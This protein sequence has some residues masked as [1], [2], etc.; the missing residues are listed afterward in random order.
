MAW[1]TLMGS[2]AVFVDTAA[3]IKADLGLGMPRYPALDRRRNSGTSVEEIKSTGT[4][5]GV[6]A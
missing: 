1:L 6:P 5:T 4:Q 2:A 3:R